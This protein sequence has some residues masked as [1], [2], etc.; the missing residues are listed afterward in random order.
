MTT[1]KHTVKDISC[2]VCGT[3]VGWKYVSISSHY[4]HEDGGHFRIWL[5]GYQMDEVGYWSKKRL[6]PSVGLHWRSLILS[7]G[8]P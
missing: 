7:I 4:W 2:N 5:D 3:S 6:C 1:G 8:E